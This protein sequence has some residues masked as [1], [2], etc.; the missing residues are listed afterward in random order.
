MIAEFCCFF[1]LVGNKHDLYNLVL[2]PDTRPGAAGSTLR[3]KR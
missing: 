3:L 2:S 1:I